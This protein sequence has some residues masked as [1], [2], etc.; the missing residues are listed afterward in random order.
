MALIYSQRFADSLA[1]RLFSLDSPFSKIIKKSFILL[2][3]YVVV[4]CTA[5]RPGTCGGRGAGVRDPLGL[6]L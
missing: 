3:M 6:E 4:L 2:L 1:P 5:F